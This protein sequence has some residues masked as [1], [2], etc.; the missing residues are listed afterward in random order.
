MGMWRKASAS[1]RLKYFTAEL[2]SVDE[3]GWEK[4]MDFGNQNPWRIEKVQV[5]GRDAEVVVTEPVLGAGEMGWIYYLRSTED[6]WRIARRKA[7]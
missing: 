3:R 5:D 2:I 4:F 7:Q 6:G 1:F